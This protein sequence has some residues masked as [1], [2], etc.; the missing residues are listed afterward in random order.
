MTKIKTNVKNNNWSF[1]KPHAFI[2][3]HETIIDNKS[4]FYINKLNDGSY[5]Y[6]R[7]IMYNSRMYS[8]KSA[9]EYYKALQKAKLTLT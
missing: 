6:N 3:I 1:K 8:F 5:N 2:T 9:L 7:L 4:C